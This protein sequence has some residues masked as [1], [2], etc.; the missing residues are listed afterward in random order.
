MSITLTVMGLVPNG[1]AIL[2]S[3][4]AIDD[5]IYVSGY[6]GDAAGALRELGQVTVNPALLLK[7][8][9]PTPRL[10]L[11]MALRGLASAAIDISDGFLSDLGHLLASSHVSAQLDLHQVPLSDALLSVFGQ[12]QALSLA[13]SGGDDYELCFTANVQHREQIASIARQQ[14]LPIARLGKIVGGDTDIVDTDGN[15]LRAPGYNHFA[16]E[17]ASPG[18]EK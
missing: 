18:R 2:R 5:D 7:Y 11:G 13:L 17:G 6:L 14:G 15:A 16:A 9:S 3:G 10:D 8:E 1:S 12:E 4:A